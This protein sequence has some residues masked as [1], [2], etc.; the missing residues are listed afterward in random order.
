MTMNS[1]FANLQ[2]KRLLFWQLYV[3]DRGFALSIGR[4]PVIADYD[5]RTDRPQSHELSGKGAKRLLGWIRVAEI[6]G[7]IYEYL[8][9]V[10]AQEGLSSLRA[11]HAQNLGQILE[12][13]NANVVSDLCP[14]V[15]KP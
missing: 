10:R 6:Q 13:L 11:E 4:A 8:Y 1:T 5:I 2:K 7:K 15:L 9:S 3:L 12:D 14:R